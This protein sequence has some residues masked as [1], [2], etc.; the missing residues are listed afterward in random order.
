MRSQRRSTGH[1]VRE[2]GTSDPGAGSG[3]G[4]SARAACVS[5]V[6]MALLVLT[7]H[8]GVARATGVGGALAGRLSSE[9]LT[10]RCPGRLRTLAAQAAGTTPAGFEAALPPE[11][12]AYLTGVSV[13]EGPSDRRTDLSPVRV[14][15]RL[16]WS[17]EPQA[18]QPALVC[19]YE[20]G[21]A[22]ARPLAP[23]LRQCISQ[24]SRSTSRLPE[25]TGV[26]QAVTACR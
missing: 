19:R 6:L 1:G 3:A 9:P 15:D 22:L 26:D 10:L 18:Q 24:V 23:S 13:Q 17:I 4:P 7:L 12:L 2:E 8:S 25:G 16:V 11:S 21:V 20:G 5:V 14:D